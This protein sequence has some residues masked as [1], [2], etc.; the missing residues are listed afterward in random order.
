MEY[1]NLKLNDGELVDPIDTCNVEER[2]RAGNSVSAKNTSVS[3]GL[4]ASL[5]H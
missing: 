2:E 4:T 5:Q 1:K 3:S